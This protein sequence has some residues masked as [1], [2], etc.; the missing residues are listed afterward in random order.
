MHVY[1]NVYCN[2]TW[3]NVYSKIITY[4]FLHDTLHY[5]GDVLK[6]EVADRK[7]SDSGPY[8]RSP[9]TDVSPILKKK[10]I[11]DS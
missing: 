6:M 3:H 10:N 1:L 4:L 2:N 5:P 11:K 8:G 9:C 7:I